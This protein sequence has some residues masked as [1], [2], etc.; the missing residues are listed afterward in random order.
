MGYFW[1]MPRVTCR[2]QRSRLAAQAIL[3]LIGGLALISAAAVSPPAPTGQLIDVEGRKLHLI[4]RGEGSP[5]VILESGAGEFSLD[6]ALAMPEIARLTRVCAWDRAGYAWSD[7][8][9]H[10]E[11]LD[12]TAEDMRALLR[13][14]GIPPPWILAGHAMG[15]LYARDYLRRFPDDVV[16]LVLVDPMPE[17]D[18]QVK[19]FGNTVSL[20]DMADHDLVAWPVR[21]FAPSRTSPAPER[22]SPERGLAPPF[23]RLPR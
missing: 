17:E 18:L 23:D 20:I 7:M 6:W 4:C 8:S 21:P 1:G 15:A 2:A 22:P 5:A 9:P 12:A 11:E 13:R 16:G 10:F 3:F 19:M 14:V